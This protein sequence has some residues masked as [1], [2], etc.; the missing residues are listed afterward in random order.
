MPKV[1]ITKKQNPITI[2]PK[3]LEV[4]EHLAEVE[5]AKF[6]RIGIVPG[7]CSGFSYDLAFEDVPDELDR[8]YYYGDGFKVLIDNESLVHLKGSILSYQDSLSQT[9][10]KFENPNA[11]RSCGCGSSFS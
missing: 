6:L 3:A 4:L 2:T 10:F 7:G 8:V 1:E 9:G 5:D 11:T